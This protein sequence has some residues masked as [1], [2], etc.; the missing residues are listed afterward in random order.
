M[1]EKATTGYPSVDKPWLKYYTEEDK[2]AVFQE[3]TMYQMVQDSCKEHMEDCC[4]QY[5]GNKI[6]YRV[7]MH[8]VHKA[9]NAF[10]TMGIRKGDMVTI[11]SMQ[12]PETLYAIYALNY[13]GATANMLY[14][15]ISEPEIVESVNNTSSKALLMLELAVE[16][17]EHLAGQLDIPVLLLPLSDSMSP[18]VKMLFSMKNK[19]KKHNLP[20]FSK[21]TKNVPVQCSPEMCTDSNVTAM[22]V[23]TSGTTG[24]PKGVMLSNNCINAIAYGCQHSGKNY[25]RGETFLDAIPPFLGFGISM[26]H[27]GLCTG[28]IMQII[29]SPDPD[30][31]AKNFI[32]LKSNRLV[33]GPRLADSIIRYAKGNLE[34]LIEFTGGGEA[35]A[36]DKEQAIN[37]FLKE[38]NAPTKYTSGY[39]MSEAASAI[40]FN[41]NHAHKPGSAGIPLP[42][43]NVKVLDDGI[44]QSYNAIGELCFSTP[45]IMQGYYKNPQATAEVLETDSNGVVWLHT[46]DFGYVDEDGFIFVTGRMKRIYTVFGK[47]KNLYKLFP[48]RIEEFVASLSDVESC[49]VTVREDPQ[50]AHAATAFVVA[51]DANCDKE[52]LVSNIMAAISQNLPEHLSPEAIHIISNMP[53]TTGGKIDYRALE[54]NATQK[55]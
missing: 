12:T 35:I 26:N 40:A 34:Y 54:E 16:K 39:G 17:A 28:I 9:V 41:L 27:L 36:L 33:Y 2:A 50:K 18:V 1:N 37:A 11:V 49:A 43:T 47:D 53:L 4:I 30:E 45:S 29:L 3:A 44:E 32:K 14:M 13:I 23:Y 20:T 51:T 22:L 19:R 48:Q 7:F 46:G 8:N 31:I 15:T 10:W 42:I 6:T 25:R 52:K 5:Y 55:H 21:F 24:S 38:H